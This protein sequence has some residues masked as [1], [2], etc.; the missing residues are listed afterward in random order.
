MASRGVAQPGSVLAWGA[1]GRKFESSRP[2]QLNQRLSE[3]RRNPAFS[4]SGFGKKIGKKKFENI[5][6]GDRRAIEN[7]H[8]PRAIGSYLN[9]IS[10]HI[11]NSRITAAGTAQLEKS[12]CAYCAA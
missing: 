7:N 1:R 9:N 4:Y 6:R 12:P 2:D 11:H 10:V 3:S 8:E 5:R